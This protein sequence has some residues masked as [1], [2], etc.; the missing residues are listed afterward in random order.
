MTGIRIAPHYK[1][2]RV[3]RW[4]PN[5]ATTVQKIFCANPLFLADEI[6]RKRGRRQSLAVFKSLPVVPDQIAEAVSVNVHCHHTHHAESA[7]GYQILSSKNPS[8][9]RVYAPRRLFNISIGDP[10]E[11][12]SRKKGK[13]A[14]NW[15]DFAKSISNESEKRPMP[16]VRRVGH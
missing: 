10:C 6:E 2:C 16:K 13:Q 8:K 5:D 11:Q 9:R 15:R 14:K 1:L 12:K 7:G 4:R 3:G